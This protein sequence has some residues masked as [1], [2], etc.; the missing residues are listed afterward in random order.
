MESLVKQS[1]RKMV[2]LEQTTS[3][4]TTIPL[5]VRQRQKSKFFDTPMDV[6]LVCERD[7]TILKDEKL[8]TFTRRVVAT[9]PSVLAT[10][11]GEINK[12]KLVDCDS[13]IVHME[14]I[15]RILE[16]E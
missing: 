16:Q 14:N 8:E 9:T 1:Q 13:N 7:T 5:E 2:T 10:L 3:Y 12:L 11:V 6:S 15:K 4:Y